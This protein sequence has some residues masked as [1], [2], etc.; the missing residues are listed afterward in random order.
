MSKKPRTQQGG[1]RRRFGPVALAATL[2]QIAKATLSKHG[3]DAADV[4]TRW[5]DIVGPELAAHT[6][7]RKLTFPK[8]VNAGGTLHVQVAGAAATE[9]Q[10]TEPQVIERI[11]T[12]FGYRAVA[13]LR[14]V[15]GPLPEPARP[16]PDRAPPPPLDAAE[17]R[18]LDKSV[19]GIEDEGLRSALA[20]LGRAVKAG[21][22]GRRIANKS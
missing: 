10:H 1:N 18:A 3:F 22:K 6:A 8:G 5:P 20:G 21:G 12:Y 13:R 7:P 17:Q 14:L 11:N 16:A 9:L 19:A 4:I 15:Q 2:P